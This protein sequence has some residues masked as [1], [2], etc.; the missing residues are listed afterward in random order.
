MNLIDILTT[1]PHDF[2]RKCIGATNENLN[3]DIRVYRVKGYDSCCFALE[4]KNGDF[5]TQ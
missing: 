4:T 3:F 5:L 2:Y 1:S